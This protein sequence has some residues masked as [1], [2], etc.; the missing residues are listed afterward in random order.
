LVTVGLKGIV[1]EERVALLPRLPLKGQGDQVPEPAARHGVL[2]GKQA[3]V[4]IHG[5]L[6][7]MRHGLRDE[8]ASHPARRRS[9]NRRREE[10]PYVSAVARA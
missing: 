3:V 2:I 6:V 9:G 8:V 5:E 10:E 1:H 4:G 7:V